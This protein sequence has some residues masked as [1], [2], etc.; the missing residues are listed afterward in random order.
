MGRREEKELSVVKKPPLW[1][2]DNSKPEGSEG[3]GLLP[4]NPE[5][6]PSRGLERT[7]PAGSSL[8]FTP[9]VKGAAQ[10]REGAGGEGSVE[11]ERLEQSTEKEGEGPK[12]K[13]GKAH[14][15]EKERQ[16]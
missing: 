6:G 7:G 13:D 14:E 4:L 8:S 3:R 10:Q 11:G 2:W 5:G 12:S 15:R 16:R 1:F 9:P